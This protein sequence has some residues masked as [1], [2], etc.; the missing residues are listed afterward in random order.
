ML[1]RSLCQEDPPG[2]G[3]GNAIQ[4][5]FLGNP[6]DRGAWQAAGQGVAK[7]LDTTK[8]LNTH[9]SKSFRGFPVAVTCQ[10]PLLPTPLLPWADKRFEQM[11]DYHYLPYVKTCVTMFSIFADL[12]KWMQNT[13][14]KAKLIIKGRMLWIRICKAWIRLTYWLVLQDNLY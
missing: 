6:V 8:G 9:F 14:L 13:G 3:N 11:T 2:E 5:S 12:W 7:E 1:A 10:R 4:Y